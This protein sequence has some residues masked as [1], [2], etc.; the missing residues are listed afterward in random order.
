MIYDG[1]GDGSPLG[2]YPNRRLFVTGFSRRVIRVQL[3]G[4]LWTR[5]AWGADF[6]P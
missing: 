1:F 6:H 4:S 2:S 5:F 3:M